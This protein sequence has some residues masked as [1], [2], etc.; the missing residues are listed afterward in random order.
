MVRIIY[1]SLSN[2]MKMMI[3]LE[4]TEGLEAMMHKCPEINL[5]MM[6]EIFLKELGLM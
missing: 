3:K 6:M 4:T 1:S 5:S 2:L